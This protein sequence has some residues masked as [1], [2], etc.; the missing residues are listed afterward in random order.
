MTKKM[1]VFDATNRMPDG[2]FADSIHTV[3]DAVRHVV[4]A[5]NYAVEFELDDPP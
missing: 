4:G 3:F 5:V 2:E 1:M